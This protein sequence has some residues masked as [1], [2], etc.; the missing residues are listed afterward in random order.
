MT[1]ES[2]RMSDVYYLACYLACKVFWQLIIHFPTFPGPFFHHVL[3][4]IWGVIFGPIVGSPRLA[5]RRIRIHGRVSAMISWPVDRAPAVGIPRLCMRS[6]VFERR[7]HIILFR[8]SS[9]RCPHGTQ[10]FMYWFSCLSCSWK[11][12]WLW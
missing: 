11:Y 2:C 4:T 6:S 8:L 10:N 5:S 12:M 3:I 7:A 1:V 9:G